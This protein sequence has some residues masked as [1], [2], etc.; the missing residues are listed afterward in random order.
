MVS[1]KC[2]HFA[3]KRLILLISITDLDHTEIS[4]GCMNIR[5]DKCVNNLSKLLISDFSAF[6]SD[7]EQ[8]SG[9]Q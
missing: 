2:R 6:S 4:K 7:P 8:E 1:V 3:I 5:H 9:S